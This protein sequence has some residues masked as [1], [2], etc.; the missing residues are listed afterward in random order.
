MPS[1]LRAIDIFCGCGG[2]TTGLKAAGFRVLAG[3][4]NAAAPAE[5]F[6]LNHPDVRLIQSDIRC[7][8]AE[9]TLVGLALRPGELDLLAGCSPCQGFSRLRTRNRGRAA[10]DDRNDLILEFIRFAEALL[11]KT[12]LIENVPGLVHDSRFTDLVIGLEGLG[13]SVAASVLDLSEFGVPQR[14]KR[15]ILLASRSQ[16]MPMPRPGRIRK[17]VRTVIGHLSQPAKSTDPLHKSVT[18]HSKPVLHKIGRIPRNGGSRIDLGP[19]GQLACHR[20]LEGFWDVYGRM[21]W[22]EPSPTITRFSFNPS[23]GRYLHPSQDRAITLREAALLQTLPVGYKFPLARYGRGAVASMIGEAL[24]PAFV[25]HLG[26]HI[27]A[28]LRARGSS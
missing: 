21:S 19:A 25:T 16:L 18:R 4:E 28:R 14:R 6:R 5:A 1:R 10:D 20:R 23:K 26:R 22:D 13:Y 11:P 12:V 24:P 2:V 9:E 17:T 15:L 3:I 27:A 7:I 8:P